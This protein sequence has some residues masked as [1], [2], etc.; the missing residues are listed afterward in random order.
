MRSLKN[1]T[2][3]S[4]IP[5]ACTSPPFTRISMSACTI[6]FASL[7]EVS[8]CIFLRIR[9][10][11]TA[12]VCNFPPFISISACTD[13]F[14]TLHA[15][16]VCIFFRVRKDA[17][18]CACTFPRCTKHLFLVWETI[19][20]TAP[21]LFVHVLIFIRVVRV[22]PSWIKCACTL[23]SCAP[24]VY[25]RLHISLLCS[26]VQLKCACSYLCAHVQK[27]ILASH[28]LA[29]LPLR[30]SAT[31]NFMAQSAISACVCCEI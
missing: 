12:R 25:A 8:T 22:C 3:A 7:R 28:S 10:T 30:Q 19:S 21:S 1:G 24:H 18:V 20:V 31:C 29:V 17:I 16:S 2:E 9:T 15:I 14:E 4:T 26:C 6:R 5:W 27:R 11:K 13:R 23:F